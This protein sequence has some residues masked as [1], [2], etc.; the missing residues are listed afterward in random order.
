MLRAKARLDKAPGGRAVPEDV[1]PRGIEGGAVV[2]DID[3]APEA[4]GLEVLRGVDGVLHRGVEVPRAHPGGEQQLRIVQGPGHIDGPV[5]REGGVQRLLRA[6]SELPVEGIRIVGKVKARKAGK[7]HKQREQ[8]NARPDPPVFPQK[9]QQRLRPE[10]GGEGDGHEQKV[11][12]VYVY[13]HERA[14]H[15]PAQ[16]PDEQ[17]HRRVKAPLF[18]RG[19]KPVQQRPE[20]RKAEGQGGG[21]EEAEAPGAVPPEP[22]GLPQQDRRHGAEIL[23]DSVQGDLPRPRRR[24]LRHREGADGKFVQEPVVDREKAHERQGQRREDQPREE[25]PP[26]RPGP[27]IEE[28]EPQQQRHHRPDG[29]V[30]IEGE[31]VAQGRERQKAPVPEAPAEEAEP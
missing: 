4:Q 8:Q 16:K 14:L 17:Q 15:D 24:E 6:E 27:C 5:V 11:H 13:G 7:A 12:A 1:D 26:V 21:I 10:G 25:K 3:K 20:S 29:G 18:E 23:R 31:P 22:V 19:K 9:A 30:G 28:H 2:P